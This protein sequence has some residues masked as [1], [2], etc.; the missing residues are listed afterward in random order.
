MEEPAPAE[1]APAE[2]TALSAAA[3]SATITDDAT[4][5]MEKSGIDEASRKDSAAATPTTTETRASVFQD[6]VT[7]LE[8]P[9]GERYIILEIFILTAMTLLL[10]LLY[11]KELKRRAEFQMAMDIIRTFVVGLDTIHEDKDDFGILAVAQ[12]ASEELLYLAN[13]NDELQKEI[14]L[15]IGNL[16]DGWIIYQRTFYFFSHDHDSWANSKKKCE[17]EG[18]KLLSMETFQEQYFINRQVQKRQKFYWFGVFKDKANKWR[19]LSGIEA[20]VTYWRTGEPRNP[21]Q[22]HCAAIGLDCGL[23]CW[24]ALKCEERIG[25][26]CK[27]VPDDAWL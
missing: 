27:K 2:P 16:N 10:F 5:R 12:N 24:M 20:K 11:Q 19:W 25:Y 6:V 14:D 9:T 4:E 13:K 17:N 21:H 26:I 8:S 1:P 23:N 3:P 22:N 15:L 18:A 7:F